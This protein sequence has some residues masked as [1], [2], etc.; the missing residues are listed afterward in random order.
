[1]ATSS[2]S[3]TGKTDSLGTEGVGQLVE[4]VLGG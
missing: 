3:A 4:L 2:F 1:M